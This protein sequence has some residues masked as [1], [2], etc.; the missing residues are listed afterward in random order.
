MIDMTKGF[1]IVRE[2]E[3]TPAELWHA[4]TDPD[5]AA[6][7]WH[8]TGLRTPRDTVT[9]DARVGGRYAYTMVDDAT[10]QEYPTGGVYREV[11]PFERLVFTWGHPD[12]D[13]DD[14]P[15]VSVTLTPI[16]GR[17]RM[18]FTL[19]GVDAQP[20]DRYMYDGWDSAL[21]EF[22]IHV[23]RKEVTR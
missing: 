14:T 15:V 18:T 8:P 5:E 12:S 3:A 17:T 16:G 11:A 19:Q 4:W 10:A 1:T 9:I 20:G 13:P 6:H 7:W 23:S 22:R 2:F 21:E